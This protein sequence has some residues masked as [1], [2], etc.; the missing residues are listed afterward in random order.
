[1]RIAHWLLVISVI[2][3]ATCATRSLLLG[4]AGRGRALFQSLHCI[5]CHSVNG[6]GG[7]SAPELGPG[8][9]RGFSPYDMAALMWNHAPAMWG[10]MTRQDVP[11]PALDEQQAADLFVYFYASGYFETPGNA[12]RG[13]QLFLTRRCGQCH[14]IDSPLRAAVRPVAEWDSLWDPIALA[15]RMWNHSRDMTRALDGSAVPYP[16]LS[17][18]ELTD[19]LSW[20]RNLRPQGHTAGFAPASPEIGRTLLVSKGCAECHRGARTLEAHRT[21]YGLTDLAAAMWNHPFRTGYHQTP[22]NDEEMRRLVGYLVAVQFFDERGDP[23]QGERVFQRKRCA[24]CHD[25]PSSGA[26][27]RAMMA[28][29]MTSLGLVAALWKHGPEMMNRMQRQKIAWPRFAGSEMADLSA[30]LHGL[31]F[32]R[33]TIGAASEH[34]RTTAPHGFA[35]VAQAQSVSFAQFGLTETGCGVTTG[36]DGASRRAQRLPIA[37]GNSP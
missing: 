35:E 36:P 8:R 20:L 29:R 5:V 30:Y 31:E 14:G 33:R 7:K 23:G 6:A 25:H 34:N 1:M 11:K 27:A 13:R 32:K 10:A 9:D 28:G 15:Q 21:R 3:P 22:L 4:D 17:G 37:G 12:R 18:Q 24:V 26:P 19:L 16:L 2:T